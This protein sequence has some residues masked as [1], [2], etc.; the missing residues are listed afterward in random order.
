[1]RKKHVFFRKK[2]TQMFFSN[3]IST[4]D[5]TPLRLKPPFSKKKTSGQKPPPGERDRLHLGITKNLQVIVIVKTKCHCPP[6][7]NLM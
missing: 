2:K 3:Y 4:P 6:N 5:K 7:L 1:M